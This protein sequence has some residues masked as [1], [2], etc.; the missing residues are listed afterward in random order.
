[1]KTNDLTMG[2]IKGFLIQ[3]VTTKDLSKDQVT[4][5]KAAIKCVDFVSRIS[6][7]LRK[8][9]EENQTKK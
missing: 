3:L 9:L 6:P 1:M 2:D 8:V 4:A 5:L 7:G